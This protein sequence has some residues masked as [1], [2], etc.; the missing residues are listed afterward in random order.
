MSLETPAGAS[1]AGDA[2]LRDNGLQQ[3]GNE[4]A[5]QAPGAGPGQ[6]AAKRGESSS[7]SMSGSSK[8]IISR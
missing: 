1:E 2:G 8:R 6:A 5:E 4:L 7:S 3:G